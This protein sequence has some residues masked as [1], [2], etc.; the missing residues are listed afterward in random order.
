MP[1]QEIDGEEL[2]NLALSIVGLVLRDGSHT[3]AE[4]SEHFGYSEKTIKKAVRTIGNTEHLSECQTYFY[5]DDDLLE[6]GEVDFSQ[7]FAN[8]SEPPALSKR[9]VTSLATGLD[10]LAALPQFETNE[11]LQALRRIVGGSNQV[12]SQRA[13]MTRA[14]ELVGRIQ[15]AM[16]NSVAIDCVYVNQLGE[17]ASRRIDPL[18][19]D[20]VAN[21]HYLRGY[22]HKNQSVRSFRLD[23]MLDAA[24]TGEP[25]SAA[26]KSATIP[27]EVFGDGHKEQQVLISARPEA[28]EIFWN[29]P[30]YSEIRR[31]NDELVGH[32]LVGSLR[33]LGRHIARYGGL[34]RVIE[35]QEAVV[36]VREFAQ[37][38]ID[39][40]QLRDE[41]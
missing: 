31:E 18:R 23:R 16:L 20:F 15:D 29:F 3:V 5:V 2:F 38:A 10:F 27:D 19:I 21:K 41:D 26:A 34:V 39:H 14:T 1:K 13:V 7:G 25:I 32:I 9:Q 35:P 33:A 22:C 30:S 12:Q 11:E 40:G 6:A 28:S 37:R 4:L 17:K 36:A 8:L 24:V